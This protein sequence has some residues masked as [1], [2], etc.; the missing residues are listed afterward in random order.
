MLPKGRDFTVA[1]QDGARRQHR[2]EAR[3]HLHRRVE[4]LREP[5]HRQRHRDDQ[6]VQRR[7]G[8][9]VLPE[10][11]DEIQVKS[12]GYT[13]E[14]GGSTGGVINVVTRSG[15]NEWQAKPVFNFEGDALDGGPRRRPCAGCPPTPAAPNTSR[16]QRTAIPGWSRASRSAARSSATAHGCLRPISRPSIHTER[17]V[18]FTFDDSTATKSSDETDHYFS[19]EPDAQFERRAAHARGLRLEPV[20]AGRHAA[21]ARRLH[22]PARKFRCIAKRQ[23]YTLSGSADWVATPKLYVGARAG[24][25][26]HQPHQRRTSSRQPLYTFESDKHGFL[27][28]PPDASTSRRV[29]NRF[30]QRRQHGRSPVARQCP[31]G[32]AHTTASLGGRHTLKAGVQLDRRANDVDKGGSANVVNIFWDGSFQGTARPLRLLSRLE[33]PD[34]SEAGPTSPPATSATQRSACSSRTRGPIGTSG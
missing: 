6:P 27:D 34:R 15:T 19:V 5:V 13:A 20:T 11:V 25:Y 18:T 30:D 32:C 31:G 12:S 10:L 14:Y 29:P 23:N 22:L 33:Q 1:G 4:R 26:R 7:V 9:E 17:T 16:I 8:D 2:A 24:Y 28:V 21:R 3:G